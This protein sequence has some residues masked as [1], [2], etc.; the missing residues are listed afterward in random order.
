M[1]TYNKV[2]PKRGR[3][4]QIW[5]YYNNTDN[6]DWIQIRF[7]PKNL[8]SAVISES[9][10]YQTRWQLILYFIGNG[11]DVDYAVRMVKKM[12]EDYFDRAA[13]DHVDNLARDIKA[14]KKNWEYWDEVS[15][16][17]KNIKDSAI[18]N[19]RV[20]RYQQPGGSRVNTGNGGYFPRRNTSYD[21]IRIYGNTERY[22]QKKQEEEEYYKDDWF[23]VPKG[24][25]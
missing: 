7:W 12:G 15:K 19:T 20:A 21:N 3:Q 22:Y 13:Y 24:W 9:L 17:R 6:F 10:N 8:A 16:R 11:M 2:V 18:T 14:G 5:N 23:R 4:A 1:S 25:D